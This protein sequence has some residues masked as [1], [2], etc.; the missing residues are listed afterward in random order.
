MGT[1]DAEF[2]QAIGSFSVPV[3]S[4]AR[5]TRKL[6]HHVLPEVVEVA[7]VRQKT[8]GFGTGIK[9]NSEHFCWFLPASKHLSV[10]FNYGAELPDPAQLLEGTGKFYRHVK[11]RS[12]EQLKDPALIELLRFSTTYRVPAVRRG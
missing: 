2:E 1:T 6:I 7:W 5:E 8:I 4:L 9:K 3:Q 12:A 10:G 11:I